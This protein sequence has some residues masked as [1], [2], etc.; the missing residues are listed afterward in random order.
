MADA[1]IRINPDGA[2]GLPSLPASGVSL[3][4][5]EDWRSPVESPPAPGSVAAGADLAPVEIRGGDLLAWRRLQLQEGGRPADL[6]WLL[7][8]A[9]DLDWSSLQRLRISPEGS[10]SLAVPLEHLEA[11]WQRHRRADE[12]LQYLV[13]VCP[14]RDL[15][16]AVAPGVL[17]PRQETELLVDLAAALCAEHPPALWADLGTGSGCLAAALARQ[18]PA[19]AG[20]AV[21]RSPAALNQAAVN[22]RRTGCGARVQLLEGCWW[23]PLQPWWGRLEVVVVNPPYI[24]TAVWSA[25]EPGVRDHEPRLALD[26]GVDGLADLRQIAAGALEGLAPGGWLLVE[27][28]HDQSAAVD[29]LLREAGLEEVAVHAD[30]EGT[31]RFA[32]ACS[33]FA[34]PPDHDADA[35]P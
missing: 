23:Q 28:H 9:A 25:L 35:L 10:V 17:I 30:L 26:G 27:H 32:V 15:E 8:M 6:D 20:L 5:R 33:P 7:A 34:S 13:G 21:D 29:R 19:S 11:L 31:L 12:P 2:G 14:W 3:Q 16:L 1:N 18:W 24:P 4:G 22:L